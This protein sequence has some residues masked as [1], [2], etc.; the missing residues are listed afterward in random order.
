MPIFNIMPKCSLSILLPQAS[1]IVLNEF[2]PF[3]SCPCPGQLNGWLSQSVSDIF[4]FSVFR[5]HCRS[6]DK[7]KDKDRDRDRDKDKDK[8]KDIDKD[9]DKDKDMGQ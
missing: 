9:K 2:F 3:L 7:D 4:Y 8:D 1:S 6:F 5:E